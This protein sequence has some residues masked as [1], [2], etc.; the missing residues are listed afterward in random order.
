MDLTISVCIP[1]V[2]KHI[3]LLPRCIRSIYKQIILP[4]EVIISISSVAD[5]EET[6]KKV[7]ELIGQFRRRLNIKV[8]YTTEKKFA[9]ENR[10]I[11]IAAST[12][13]IISLIDA[14]DNMYHNRLYVIKQ[15]FKEDPECLGVLHHFT[16][17][18]GE[19][20]EKWK[21]SLESV[22]PYFYT[23]KLH[24]GHPSFRR[25]LFTEFKYSSMPRIQ[26]IKFVEYILP[27]YRSRLR[28]YEKKL[29][30]YNSGDSTFY[31]EKYK[32]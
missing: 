15:I 17:N 30:N 9:G 2:D 31:S 13:E 14:D 19:R 26:D 4:D 27:K 28:V 22:K 18:H 6:T 7:E 10:N 11:A 23:D 24:F 5:I 16:E 32:I 29:T 20:N 12:G 25:Q 21:F 8:I 3:P 1:C